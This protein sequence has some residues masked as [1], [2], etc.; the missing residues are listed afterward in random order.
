[1][2]RIWYKLMHLIRAVIKTIIIAVAWMIM[3]VLPP[4]VFIIG[5]MG[6]NG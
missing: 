3:Y 1:M 5:I 6:G 4:V 2:H